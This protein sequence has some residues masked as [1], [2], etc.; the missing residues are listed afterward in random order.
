[1]GSRSSVPVAGDFLYF[2]AAVYHRYQTGKFIAAQTCQHV[3]GAKL[4]LHPKRH[5]LQ[6][7]VSDMMAIA[8]VDLLELIEVDVDQPNIPAVLRGLRSVFPDIF[9][10]EAIVNLGE[11]IKL[12]AVKK[13]GVKAPGFNGQVAIRVAAL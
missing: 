8:I 9:P 4:V 2:R 7:H 12:R 13:I 10:A 6:V 1:M 5:F 11:Q 3:M